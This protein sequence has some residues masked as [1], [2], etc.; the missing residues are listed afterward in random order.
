MAA[1][2]PS[3]TMTR[4]HRESKEVFI[5]LFRDA[6]LEMARR[7]VAKKYGCSS[8]QE[9]L[10]AATEHQNG[11]PGEPDPAHLQ[12]LVDPGAKKQPHSGAWLYDH[13]VG[14]RDLLADLGDQHHLAVAALFH[15]MYGTESYKITSVP[16]E[17]GFSEA[18]VTEECQRHVRV[19]AVAA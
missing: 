13:L 2:P 10:E 6:S 5:Q 19:L 12:L 17:R 9:L 11:V 1:L 15:S 16:L 3:P 14:T 8:W 7:R 4:L 18:K